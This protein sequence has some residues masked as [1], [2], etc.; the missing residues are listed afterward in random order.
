ML[1]PSLSRSSSPSPQPCQPDICFLVDAGTKPGPQSIY[2]LWKAFHDDPHLGGSSGMR[3]SNVARE[4]PLI[5]FTRR[6]THNGWEGSPEPICCCTEFR[7]QNVQH[8][9]FV[10][11]IFPKL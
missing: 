4:I 1:V 6:D 8:P 11:L 5:S 9:G 2:Y 10:A 3:F 7:V